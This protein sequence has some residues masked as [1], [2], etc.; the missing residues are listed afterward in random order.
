M[1]IYDY[2]SNSHKM[3]ISIAFITEYMQRMKEQDTVFSNTMLERH[4]DMMPTIIGAT[5][6]AISNVYER[7]YHEPVPKDQWN[8]LMDV[9]LNLV[10]A[11]MYWAMG[12]VSNDHLK[13]IYRRMNRATM[14]SI[15]TIDALTTDDEKYMWHDN[16]ETVNIKNFK[17]T[18]SM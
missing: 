1:E 3:S 2:F 7:R 17:S 4:S 15:V 18:D 5:Y 10:M 12:S 8:T 11:H 14:E 9:N 16:H 13:F 6:R